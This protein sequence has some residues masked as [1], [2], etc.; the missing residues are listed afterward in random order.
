MSRLNW[1]QRLYWG[2]FSKPAEERSLFRFLLDHPVGSILEIGIGDGARLR[3]I[4]KLVRPVDSCE[5][6]RYIGVDDF[7]GS[8]AGRAHLTLKQAHQLASQL[9]LRASLVPGPP[10]QAVAR[11]AHRFGAS[12]LI[13]IDGGI[14]PASPTNG[15]LGCWLNR[16]AHSTSTVIASNQ[17]GQPLM[18][19]N[20]DLLELPIVKA[21]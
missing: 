12:D 3:R 16:L 15:P 17:P 5:K 7:E 20:G 13:I 2:R 14:D 4:V 6:V 8:P 9:G 10:A 19:V 1:F 18:L 11:V 21:A